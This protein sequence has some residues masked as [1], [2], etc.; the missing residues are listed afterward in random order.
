MPVPSRTSTTRP[1]GRARVTWPEG[2]ERMRVHT[3]RTLRTIDSGDHIGVGLVEEEASRPYPDL[4]YP[5]TIQAEV[6]PHAVQCPRIQMP[7]GGYR[8]SGDVLLAKALDH[9]PYSRLNS[10]SVAILSFSRGSVLE[11]EP[12]LIQ[13]SYPV[14]PAYEKAR[15]S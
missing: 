5:P 4:G 8:D 14:S 7:I 2:L 13:C 12:A 3:P 1:A 6:A 15:V 10:S 9:R 11:S